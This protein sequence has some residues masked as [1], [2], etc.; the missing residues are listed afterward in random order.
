MMEGRR[1]AAVEAYAAGA[2]SESEME[3]G[4]LRTAMASAAVAHALGGG[5]RA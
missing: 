3:R 4:L 2:S 1:G 5:G